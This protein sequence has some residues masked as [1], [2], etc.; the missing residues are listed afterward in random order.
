MLPFPNGNSRLGENGEPQNV[1]E[2]GSATQGSSPSEYPESHGATG[3]VDGVVVSLSF[4]L[5]PG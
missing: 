1:Q 2:G 3:A 5:S 4:A